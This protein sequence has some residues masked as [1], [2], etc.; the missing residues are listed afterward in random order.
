MRGCNQRYI[1]CRNVLIRYYLRHVLMKL[2]RRR[3]LSLITTSFN[4]K[5][6]KEIKGEL[7]GLKICKMYNVEKFVFNEGLA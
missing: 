2:Y 4:F 1:L 5:S 3:N 7:L 6:S